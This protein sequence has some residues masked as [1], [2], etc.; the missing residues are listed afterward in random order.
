MTHTY[1]RWRQQDL[2]T[3]L[4]LYET[5]ALF[6]LSPGAS[7]VRLKLCILSVPLLEF[8]AKAMKRQKTKN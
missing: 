4:P 7:G 5:Q 6:L 8:K 1:G 2:N 3:D